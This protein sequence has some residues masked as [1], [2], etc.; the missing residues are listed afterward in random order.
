MNCKEAVVLDL[1]EIN[2][3]VNPDE[4]KVMSLFPVDQD[5]KK[6]LDKMFLV[7]ADSHTYVVQRPKRKPE[8]PVA[9]RKPR[10]IGWNVDYL[11]GA[12]F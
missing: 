12:R 6:M 5:G 10:P 4:A 7:S 11:H 8:I 9:S 1:A 2:V 3:K